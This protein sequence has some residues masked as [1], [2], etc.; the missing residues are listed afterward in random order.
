MA[1]EHC[2]NKIVFQTSRRMSCCFWGIFQR[3]PSCT[4]CWDNV[5]DYVTCFKSYKAILFKLRVPGSVIFWIKVSFTFF[6]CFSCDSRDLLC[7]EA[8]GKNGFIAWLPYLSLLINGT[9]LSLQHKKPTDS[10]LMS[11]SSR[12]PDSEAPASPKYS[13]RL[14]PAINS[15]LSEA[16]RQEVRVCCLVLLYHLFLHFPLAMLSADFLF[17]NWSLCSH[18]FCFSRNFGCLF[19]VP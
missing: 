19:W 17:F 7:E 16:S 18:I 10:L 5:L 9:I 6:S 12:S 13:D 2:S 11:C 15:Y 4:L 3:K 1:A 8:V 14:S